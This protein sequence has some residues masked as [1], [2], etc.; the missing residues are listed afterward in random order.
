MIGISCRGKC[1]EIMLI[2]YFIIFFFVK[3]FVG[4]FQ[5]ILREC[6]E[7]GEIEGGVMN[8]GIVKGK[9][10][11]KGKYVIYICQIELF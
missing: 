3:F 10:N 6:G 2:L 8:M 7:S 5:E 11:I 9:N 1:L 4:F